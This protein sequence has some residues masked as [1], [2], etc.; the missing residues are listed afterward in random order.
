MGGLGLGDALNDALVERFW[1]IIQ[2]LT[3]GGGG[4]AA[5]SLKPLVTA[6]P[7]ERGAQGQQPGRGRWFETSLMDCGAG[8]VVWACALVKREMANRKGWV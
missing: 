7:G 1:S 2:H 4:G 8:Y 6:R 5:G 3:P